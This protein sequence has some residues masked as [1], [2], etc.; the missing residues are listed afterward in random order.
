MGMRGSRTVLCLLATAALVLSSA[1]RAVADDTPPL[2]AA[3]PPDTAAQGSATEEE[4]SA[5]PPDDTEGTP[6]PPPRTPHPEPRVIV[7]VQKVRG[8]HDRGAVE[9][10]ARLGW[11]RIVGCHKAA[12]ARGVVA[13]GTIKVRLEV[14]AAGTVQH[15]KRVASEL[16]GETSKCLVRAMR[17][18]PMPRARRGSTVDASIRVAPGDKP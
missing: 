3:A 6:E 15:V 7:A 5:A 9:R 13:R 17:K 14:S 2:A 18:V 11:G 10:A 16:D 4:D 12:G 1:G 8:P